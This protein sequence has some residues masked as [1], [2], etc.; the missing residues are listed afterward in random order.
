MGSLESVAKPIQ[1]T[2][3][4]KAEPGT[5]ENWEYKQYNNLVHWGMKMYFM[6]WW[7]QKQFTLK[8][9]NILLLKCFIA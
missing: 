3:E 5:S 7:R 4:I 8:I 9:G 6:W 1:E 2:G